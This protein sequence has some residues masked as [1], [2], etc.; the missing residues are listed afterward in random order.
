MNRVRLPLRVYILPVVAGLLVM[1]AGVSAA[2]DARS[3]GPF[4]ASVRSDGTILASSPGVAAGA[5]GVT[6]RYDLTFPR[7]VSRCAVVAT[8]GSAQDRG[9]AGEQS[10]GLE[11][12]VRGGYYSSPNRVSVLETRNGTPTD[13]SFS[14]VAYC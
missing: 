6:G 4:W 7:D 11:I 13:Y 1:T 2:Q 9:T 14:I 5:H 10:A 8:S 3:S 12:L